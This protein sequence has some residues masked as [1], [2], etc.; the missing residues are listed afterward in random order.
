MIQA[1]E[2]RIGNWVIH[3]KEGEW[4]WEFSNNDWGWYEMDKFKPIPI[5]GNRLS[6]YGLIKTNNEFHFDDFYL[7]NS[8]GLDWG[9]FNQYT[10]Y[11][12]AE[13]KYIHQLQNIYFALTG[14]ELEIK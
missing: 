9:L 6:K 10:P 7:C 2:L 5:T 8:D 13:I 14:K 12:L 1:N 11:P 4:R 3:P